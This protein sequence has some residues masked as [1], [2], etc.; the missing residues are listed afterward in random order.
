MQYMLGGG[1]VGVILTGKRIVLAGC[2]IDICITDKSLGVILS[3]ALHMHNRA[4]CDFSG[5]ERGLTEKSSAT[6]VHLKIKIILAN[7]L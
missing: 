3:Q 5:G 2:F 7:I 1:G 4:T 6:L